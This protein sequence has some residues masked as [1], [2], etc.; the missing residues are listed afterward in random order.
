MARLISPGAP[1]IVTATQTYTKVEC[2][3]RVQTRTNK[4]NINVGQTFTRHVTFALQPVSS[5]AEVTWV[6]VFKTE[7]KHEREGEKKKDSVCSSDRR[8]SHSR[9]QFLESARQF[10][11]R[12]LEFPERQAALA[13]KTQV[14]SADLSFLSGHA[15][16]ARRAM[17]PQLMARAD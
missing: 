13:L 9:P 17:G 2:G 16:M 12:W 10:Q 5:Q 8:G 3:G 6:L 11:R 7:R 14:T 15:A 4:W 1:K